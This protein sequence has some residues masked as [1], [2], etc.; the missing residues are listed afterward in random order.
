MKI[1]K[2]A[3]ILLFSILIVSCSE[4]DNAPKN[5]EVQHFVWR[6]LNAYYLWQDLVPDLDD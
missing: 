2:T 5:I 3:L 1:V 6:G 4:K